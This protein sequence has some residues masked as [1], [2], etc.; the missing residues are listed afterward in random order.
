MYSNKSEKDQGLSFSKIFNQGRDQ[1]R[2][3]LQ[4]KLIFIQFS[5]TICDY[6][7]KRQVK[8]KDDVNNE[9]TI[10][11]NYTHFIIVHQ[12]TKRIKFEIDIEL[13]ACLKRI[14]GEL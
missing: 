5:I 10:A 8:N 7:Q 13:G 6:L 11:Q 12:R 2:Q 9:T 1:I 3:Y 4:N 14:R